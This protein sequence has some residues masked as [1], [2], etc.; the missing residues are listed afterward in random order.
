MRVEKLKLSIA[1]FVGLLCATILTACG[2]DSLTLEEYFQRI[3]T[4]TEIAS[5]KVDALDSQTGSFGPNTSEAEVI[6][7]FQQNL[8]ATGD[9]LGEFGAVLE[10]NTPPSEIESEHDRYAS[11]YE[12]FESSIRKI[13]AQLDDVTTPDQLF[14]LIDA[15]GEELS[16]ISDEVLASCL[17]LQDAADEKGIDADLMCTEDSEGPSSA[18]TQPATPPGELP[19]TRVPDAGR[20]HVQDGEPHSGYSSAPATSGAHYGAPLAPAPWVIFE[21]EL[22]PEIY[23]HNLE[24]GGIGI[25][26]DCPT[27]CDALVGQLTDLTI[28]LIGDGNKV[29]LAPHGGT[30]ATISLAAWTFL[31]QFDDFDEARI[32]QFVDAHESSINS[33]EPFV[34]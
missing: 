32:R 21:V 29:L 14:A 30:D 25:F 6:Q 26:Y 2:G 18:Q 33:P 31:D 5:Q 11:A 12:G 1:L 20:G 16:N 28:S 19:G 8:Q 22:E 3:T 23:V 4:A 17:A 27:G 34:R 24:H 9:I 10:A 13:A 7:A 15:T